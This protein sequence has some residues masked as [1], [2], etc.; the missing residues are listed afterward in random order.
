MASHRD[1]DHSGTYLGKFDVYCDVWVSSIWSTYRIMRLFLQAIVLR[2]IAWLCES[3]VACSNLEDHL[4]DPAL[5]PALTNA[6]TVLRKMVDEICASVPYHIGFDTNA[7][8]PTHL[9]STSYL[10]PPEFANN[11]APKALGG[12][13][14]VWPL[15]VARSVTIIP[16]E[17]KIW[18]KGRMMHVAN[19]FGIHL[20]GV[21]GLRAVGWD[22]WPLFDVDPR[23]GG[24]G[25]MDVLEDKNNIW[26][27]DII[28]SLILSKRGSAAS[29]PMGF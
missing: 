25:P 15:L 8:H 26:R 11:H 23:D 21:M 1:D 14:L 6:R 19:N 13:F 20:L 12:F 7:E 18:L 17:Q 4:P 2:C 10:S 24:R 22:G 29:V 5:L 27:S 9:L 16:Q 3:T 28:T